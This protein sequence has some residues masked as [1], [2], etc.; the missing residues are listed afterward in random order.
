MVISNSEKYNPADFIKDP[1]ITEFLNIPED[2]GGVEVSACS[3]NKRGTDSW[4]NLKFENYNNF[5]VSVIYEF[6][7]DGDMKKTGVIV[8]RANE[9]KKTNESYFR[10]NNFKLIA[11]KLQD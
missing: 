10:P 6:D 2:L 8:L 3:V 9:K 7:T 1:Y 5:T 4:C 11:R